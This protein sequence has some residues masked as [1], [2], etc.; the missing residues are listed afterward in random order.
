METTKTIELGEPPED[1]FI[2]FVISGFG[3]AEGDGDEIQSIL[4]AESTSSVIVNHAG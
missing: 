1:S 2:A 4:N 3:D